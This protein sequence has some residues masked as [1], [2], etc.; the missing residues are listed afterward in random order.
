MNFTVLTLFPD[1][2]RTVLGTS[3]LDRAAKAGVVSFE[4]QDLRQWGTGVHKSVD[5]APYGGGAGM[6]LRVDVI[7]A[8]LAEIHAKNQES[9]IKN[10][11][12]PARIILLTPQGKT[13]DQQRAEELAAE[14]RDLILI[15]GH[16]EGFDER[17]RSLVDEELS[18]GDFVLTG[19]ELP[20]LLVVDAVTRLL[21]GSL[22]S[23]ESAQEESFSIRATEARLHYVHP[24][25]VTG[26]HPEGVHIHSPRLLEYPHYTRPE[27]YAP[28]SRTLGTLLVPEILRS[29]DHAK[30]ATWRQT[31]AVERTRTKRPDLLSS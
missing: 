16:Y 31:Q 25:G 13:F 10:Q 27:M 29:G 4:V 6:V 12:N 11:G 9:R 19:G 7:D 18:I 2:V 23:D 30:I 20:A 28:A 26:K 21:P 3:M 24:P 5:D 22:G 15:A 17:I 1:M 14:Q 8:A